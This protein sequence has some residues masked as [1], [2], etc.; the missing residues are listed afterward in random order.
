MSHGAASR[1]NSGR[2]GRGRSLSPVIVGNQSLVA[3]LV[4]VWA[5]C[6]SGVRQKAPSFFSL[7]CRWCSTGTRAMAPR[8]GCA[9]F[10]VP[11]RLAC[12]RWPG[13]RRHPAFARSGPRGRPTDRTVSRRPCAGRRFGS[14]GGA[15]TSSWRSFACGMV[16]GEQAQ[17]IGSVP[18]IVAAHFPGTKDVDPFAFSIPAGRPG[19]RGGAGPLHDRGP[20][21]TPAAR[22][23]VRVARTDGVAGPDTLNLGL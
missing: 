12:R 22:V 5:P 21:G 16:K 20:G 11:R 2:F 18:A 8:N 14:S 15:R 10:D 4:E 9:G 19:R 17:A 13:R 23:I 6:S 1:S 3:A 7:R